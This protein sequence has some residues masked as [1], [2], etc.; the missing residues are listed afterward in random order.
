MP[1]LSEI[2]NTV[3]VTLPTVATPI[4]NSAIISAAVMLCERS[5]VWR[6]WLAPVVAAADDRQLTLVLPADTKVVRV[7][8]AFKNGSK[9]AVLPSNDGDFNPPALEGESLPDGVFW[10]VS[11]PNNQVTLSRPAAEGDSYLLMVSLAPSRDAA[12]MPDLLTDTFR[13]AVV[14][15]AIYMALGM[16][17]QQDGV[18][19]S[20]Q[21]EKGNFFMSEI[22]RAQAL[23]YRSHTQTAPRRRVSWA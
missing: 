13:E 18:D 16:G 7:E 1:A 2:R 6:E 10:A 17:S 20:M 21:T 9:I 11:G 8:R 4:L 3:A 22:G 14:A 23:G 12:T 15:G 19:K 5:R